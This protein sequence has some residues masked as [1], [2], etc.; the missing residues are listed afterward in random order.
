MRSLR[1]LSCVRGVSKFLIPDSGKCKF[2]EKLSDSG[3]TQPSFLFGITG[4]YCASAEAKLMDAIIC[5]E[6]TPCVIEP[7]MADAGD[8]GIQVIAAGDSGAC[9]KEYLVGT[10]SLSARSAW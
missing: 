2:P 4:L 7:R 5:S 6:E 3:T 9:N 10:G 8:D 1:L